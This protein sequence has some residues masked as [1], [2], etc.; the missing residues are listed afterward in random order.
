[1]LQYK[2]ALFIPNA[3]IHEP[4]DRLAPGWA[5]RM[6][7]DRLKRREF[8]ML[9]GGAAASWPFVAREHQKQLFAMSAWTAAFVQ[10][11]RE[12]LDRG[13]HHQ[14][15]ISPGRRPRLPTLGTQPC[16]FF[17]ATYALAPDIRFPRLHAFHL[18]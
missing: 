7:F 2:M 12:L 13:T 17:G 11:L 10:R 6:Q 18:K 8:I 9:L 4:H 14:D 5:D 1:M 15:R 3:G 16:R